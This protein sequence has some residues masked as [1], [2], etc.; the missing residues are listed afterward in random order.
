VVLVSFQFAF[1]SGCIAH[2]AGKRIVVVV[3]VVVCVCVCV[4]FVDIECR[5][6][7]YMCGTTKQRRLLTHVY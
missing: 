1:L 5:V 2:V 4:N 3:V 6:V 7:L